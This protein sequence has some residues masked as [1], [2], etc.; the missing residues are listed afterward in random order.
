MV[1]EMRILAAGA[2]GFNIGGESWE[3]GLSWEPDII[4]A[5]GTTSD[6]GP[7]YL[8][9]DAPYAGL[10]EIEKDLRAIIV[11]AKKKSIPFIVS[12][13][14]PGGSNLEL[15]R[16]LAAVD[17]IAGEAEINLKVAVIPGEIDQVVLAA[18]DYRRREDT[19]PG[20]RGQAIG[21]SIRGGCCRQQTHCGPDGTGTYHERA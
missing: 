13:G 14:S 5:Q 18:K 6:G 4:V 8:G 16:S 1:E 9:T 20:E 2:F 10:G 3:R 12:T 11:S 17:K 7:T 21:I 19:P 15:E